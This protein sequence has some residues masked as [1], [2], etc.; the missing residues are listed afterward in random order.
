MFN[1]PNFVKSGLYSALFLSGLLQ[2]QD[3]VETSALI[4]AAAQQSTAI[5]D[6][7]AAKSS[8]KPAP[9][10]HKQA[11]RAVD[12]AKP[13]SIEEVALPQAEKIE[14]SKAEPVSK[15]Q[16]PITVAKPEKL[17]AVVEDKEYT[18]KQQL[19]A[20]PEAVAVTSNSSKKVK[21]AIAVQAPSSGNDEK[22]T[23]EK[24]VVE[25]SNEAVN[26][27]IPS[28]ES[29]LNTA[30]QQQAAL[31]EPLVILDTEIPPA[32]AT[33]L[34]WTPDQSFKGIAIP[35]PVLVVNGAKPGPVVCLTAAIHG[36]ELNGIEIVRRVL[37]NLKPEKLTGTVIGVPIVNLQGFHRNSRYLADRR[38]L[39]R[40]FPGNPAGSSASRLA[41]SFFNEVISH[42]DAL[43]DLHTG[44]FYR[45]NLPQLRANTKN[46]KVLALA[47]QFGATVIVHGKGAPGTLRWA[48]VQAGIPAVTLEA[49]ESMR[50]QVAAVEHGVKGIETLLE[51]KEMLH[52]LKFWK[53]TEAIYEQTLWV[54]ADQGGILFTRVSEGDR[55]KAGDVLGVVTDP[56]TNASSEIIAP[57]KGRVIGLALNQVVMPGF[58]TFHLGVEAANLIKPELIDE[59]NGVNP[60]PDTESVDETITE[61]EDFN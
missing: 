5:A 23:A 48:A 40:Y 39:N 55:V 36:D 44:S 43:V 14:A 54:R 21:A 6:E 33:R 12:L 53:T 31:D 27:I 4:V 61:L 20:E 30:K 51:Q 9:K 17:E 32:T 56:I 11:A 60:V 37:Y 15:K 42:C 41:Y 29:A 10:K 49:G 46:P 58:A 50:L 28:I 7:P 19:I 38:D 52:S 8:E 3:T 24:N 45:T 26:K 22:N 13:I 47:K 1:K 25:A 18:A 35:T 57:F 59:Y 2:A 16:K 34:A